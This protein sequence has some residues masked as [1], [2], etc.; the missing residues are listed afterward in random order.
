MSP[1]STNS[2]Q[3]DKNLM[4]A[5]TERTRMYLN[6]QLQKDRYLTPIDIQRSN[7]SGREVKHF[8]FDMP[9]KKYEKEELDL[10][11]RIQLEDDLARLSMGC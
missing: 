5:A 3:S 7:V 4:M 6:N 2:N 9:G 1:A 8:R 10:I 11:D